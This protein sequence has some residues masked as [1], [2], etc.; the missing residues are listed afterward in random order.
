[1]PTST[2]NAMVSAMNANQF[3]SRASTMPADT[4]AIPAA[5]SFDPALRRRAGLSR[6]SGVSPGVSSR[7]ANAST[8][9]NR[10][11]A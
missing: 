3:A 4:T 10:A 7:S 5:E 9:A 1:M 8:V 2:T 11:A 6:P